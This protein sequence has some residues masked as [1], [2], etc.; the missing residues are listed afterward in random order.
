[1]TETCPSEELLER[2]CRGELSAARADE[3]RAHLEACTA[4]ANQAR[5]QEDSLELLGELRVVVERT[6]AAA[7]L[8]TTL[9]PT[10]QSARF[11][12]YQIES[13]LGVGGMA[14]VYRAVHVETGQAVALKILKPGYEGSPEIQ[15]RFSREAETMIRVRH[16]NILR[17]IEIRKDEGRTGIVMEFMP[18]GSLAEWLVRQRQQGSPT[19]LERVADM[20]LQAARGLGAAH[21]QGLVHRD[22]KP[23]NLLLDADGVVKISDFGVV[24]ALESAAWVTGTGQQIG[25]PAYMSPEQCR[26]ERATPAS[27]VYSLGVTMFELA[28]GKLPFDVEGGS[29][30]ARMLKHISE[31]PPDPRRVN[32]DVPERLADVILRCLRKPPGERYANGDAMC[33]ALEQA[34][35]PMAEPAGALPQAAVMGGLTINATL[36]RQQLERLPMRSIVAW[37]CRC[38]RRVQGFNRDPRVDRAIA[39]AESVAAGA[40]D[41][42]TGPTSSRILARMRTLRTA[43]LAAA[44]ADAPLA[45][46]SQGSDATTAEPRRSGHRPDLPAASHRPKVGSMTRPTDAADEPTASRDRGLA[47]AALIAAAR[48]A[49]AASSSASARCAADAAADAVFALECALVACREGGLPVQSFWREAQKDF[50]RLYHAKLGAPGTIGEAVPADFWSAIC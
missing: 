18:G 29:P 21:V 50:R 33:L 28:T 42:G 39:M 3:V 36:V 8:E 48:A 27:D 49:A 7:A 43:S 22:I 47:P 4:C 20:A 37:A 40:D 35:L 46:D 12:P 5:N 16:P 1:V 23:S 10:D 6:G 15:A 11:G 31:P 34:R 44:Y 30:F 14:R 38:A 2:Y 24:Q 19:D 13:L 26:G 41:T 32:P 9:V 17:I 25:T 45:P